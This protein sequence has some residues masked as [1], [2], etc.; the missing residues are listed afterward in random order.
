MLLDVGL[1][2]QIREMGQQQ[3]GISVL[4]SKAREFIMQF[5][6][7]GTIE[8]RKDAD[9]RISTLVDKDDVL[10]S[11]HRNSLEESFG[12]D[13]LA[14]WSHTKK[15][16][17]KLVVLGVGQAPA[18][19][20]LAKGFTLLETAKFG[21]LDLLASSPPW[22][23]R[24]IYQLA[25]RCHANEDEFPFLLDEDHSVGESS[26]DESLEMDADPD[27]DSDDDGSSV[28]EINNVADGSHLPSSPRRVSASSME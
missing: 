12:I 1:I 24:K 4:E 9:W 17:P 7:E 19:R 3:F 20:K 10:E 5:F 8:K 18:V 27:D 22:K 21:G 6:C 26:D 23:R 16:S 25:L 11:L 15:R 14:I 13:A 2:N 28:L